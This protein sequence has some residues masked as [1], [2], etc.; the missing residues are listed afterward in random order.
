ME[1]SVGGLKSSLRKVIKRELNGYGRETFRGWFS[2][3]GSA[4]FLSH[5]I[6]CY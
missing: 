2:P 1:E 5:R 4:P 3:R 6:E